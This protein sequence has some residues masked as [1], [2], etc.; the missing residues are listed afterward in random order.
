MPVV[1]GGNGSSSAAGCGEL[2]VILD[3]IRTIESRDDYTTPKN[4]GGASGAY[5]YVD[6]TCKCYE[7]CRSACLAPPE[8]QDV[9]AAG[10]VQAVLATFGDVAYVPIIWYWPIA[11]TGASQLDIVPTL[12]WEPA[13]R[14]R[15][16]TP[17]LAVDETKVAGVAPTDCTGATPTEDNYAL[18][19]DRALIAARF[20]LACEVFVQH[21][22][23]DVGQQR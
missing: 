1:I 3:T 8:V 11:A 4:S 16:P 5:Q 7:G 17:W 18:P 6:S 15:I 14:P 12:G 19:L 20:P 21:R 2:A 13:D 10:D 9:R 23:G 22:Q